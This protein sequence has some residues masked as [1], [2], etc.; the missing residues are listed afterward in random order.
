MLCKIKKLSNPENIQVIIVMKNNI[1]E[2]Q[3][4]GEK[5]KIKIISTVQK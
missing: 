3:K 2:Q 1:T 4:C 5:N